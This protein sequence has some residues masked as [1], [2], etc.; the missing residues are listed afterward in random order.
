[1]HV[2]C[3]L[4]VSIQVSSGKRKNA[5]VKRHLTGCTTMAGPARK[6]AC[7]G[8]LHKMCLHSGKPRLSIHRDPTVLIVEGPKLC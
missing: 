3:L 5:G 7:A 8:H 2:D 4:K 1:M 6:E